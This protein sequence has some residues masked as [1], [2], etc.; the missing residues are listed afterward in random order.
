VHPEEILAQP[1]LDRASALETGCFGELEAFADL[2]ADEL[3]VGGQLSEALIAKFGESNPGQAT[4]SSP[5]LLVQGLNDDTIPA[6]LTQYFHSQL[7]AFDQPVQ[8]AEYPG[9]GHVDVL[10]A[11]QNDVI[12]YMT[13]RFN[14]EPAPT[15]C[16]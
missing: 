2:T 3:L 6:D 11:S 16:G 15:N 9:V 13:A 5:V 10:A 4:G 14:K 12:D 1:A 7:C 8:L